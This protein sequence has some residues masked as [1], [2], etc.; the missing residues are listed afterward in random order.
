MANV[1]MKQG[2]HIIDRVTSF[3]YL[4]I[5]LDPNLTFNN[6][7]ETIR[8]KTIG[9]IKLLS[10]VTPYMPEKLCFELYKSLIRPHF[11]YGD[12]VFDCLN[13]KDSLTLQKLQN[14]AIKNILHVP[15]RTS[16]RDIHS[17]T[18]LELLVNRRWCHVATEMFKISAKLMPMNIT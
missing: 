9:K 2:P 6:H 8:R 15:R 16:T 1:Q 18:N 14:M 7:V 4:G 5:T 13:Q 10:R 3:K 12:V 17:R 11:D